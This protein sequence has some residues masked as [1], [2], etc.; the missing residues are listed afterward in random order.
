MTDLLGTLTSVL[1]GNTVSQLSNK[2]GADQGTTQNALM[3]ALPMILG[4]LNKNTN[5]QDGAGSLFNALQ[6]DHD[7]SLLDNLGGFLGGAM[8][9][10]KATDGPGILGHIFGNKVDQAQSGLAQ[11]TGLGQQQA[12]GLLATLAPIVMGALGQAQRQGGQDQAGLSGLLAQAATL[13]QVAA[14]GGLMDKL[15]PFLDSNKDGSIADDLIKHGGGLLG[16]FL[17]GK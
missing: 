8:G 12:G 17:G 16:K 14:S 9:G 11:A 2:I 1:G 3:A 7:G 13:A 15:S 6:R 10:G 5:S 4:A